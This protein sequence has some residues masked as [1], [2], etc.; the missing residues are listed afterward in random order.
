MA[1]N[2]ET[3]N[4][5][6]R[7]TY[8]IDTDDSEPIFRIVFSDDQFE[9]RLSG[10]T[11][12]GVALLVPEVR[13]LPKYPWIQHAY[14]LERRVLVPAINLQELAGEQKSYEPLWV[15]IGGDGNPVRP[16]INACQFIINSLYAALG[17]KSMAKYKDVNAGLTPEESYEKKQKELNELENQLFGDESGLKQ[18][19]INESGNAIIVPHNYNRSVH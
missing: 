2:L 5:F 18:S 10:Y 3:V 12:H 14:V 8:G 19:T 17:K 15:F 1:E 7:D 13:E 16:T 4:Q 6:L 11:D 9:K